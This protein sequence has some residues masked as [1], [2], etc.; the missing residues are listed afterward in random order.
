MS[1]LT[2]VSVLQK[3]RQSWA[4]D[5]LINGDRV[6]FFYKDSAS[7]TTKTIMKYRI[8]DFERGKSW[9]LQLNHPLNTVA[10]RLLE[11]E[12]NPVIKV[13]V[14]TYKSE[15]FSR[16]KPVDSATLPWEICAANIVYA[17]N[18]GT[19]CYV[20]LNEGL[21]FMRLKLSHTIEDLSRAFSTSASLSA[22]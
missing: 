11:D 12:T 13:D 21:N 3:D 14:E 19:G 10:T 9:E 4:R 20:W 1:I 15:G 7:P 22:S 16:E 5:L 8:N 18:V 17:Y 6:A 2:V